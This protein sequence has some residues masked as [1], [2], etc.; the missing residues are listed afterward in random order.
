[1]WLMQPEVHTTTRGSLAVITGAYE[2]VIV[3]QGV[4]EV[5]SLYLLLST[6]L[7]GQDLLLGL[8]TDNT[9]IIKVNS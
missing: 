4:L 9:I 3:I 8:T 5:L 7:L 6:F 1:V 2:I